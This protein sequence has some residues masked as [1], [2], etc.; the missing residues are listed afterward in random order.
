MGRQEA[1]GLGPWRIAV[2]CT[3]EAGEVVGCRTVRVACHQRAR[4]RVE[5]LHAARERQGR[6]DG[7]SG[8]TADKTS[9][10]QFEIGVHSTGR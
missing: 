4:D 10:R 8:V 9:Q 6:D 3:V 2:V 1:G 5:V 7:G